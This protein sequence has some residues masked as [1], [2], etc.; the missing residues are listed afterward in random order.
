MLP[1]ARATHIK[2]TRCRDIIIYLRLNRFPLG[3]QLMATSV[4]VVAPV[5]GA[6]ANMGAPPEGSLTSI[7][8]LCSRLPE[9]RW[10][11]H[12]DTTEDTLGGERAMSSSRECRSL[13]RLSTLSLSLS[14]SLSL[15]MLRCT[16]KCVGH[17]ERG[18]RHV[19]I[20]RMSS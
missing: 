11:L 17:I 19:L 15:A 5:H 20:T 7:L 14:L 3:A 10:P 18:V 1:T 4:P 12:S 2:S 13:E 16:A 6:C 8:V 9:G